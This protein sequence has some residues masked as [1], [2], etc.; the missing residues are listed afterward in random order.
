MNEPHTEAGRLAIEAEAAAL[1]GLTVERLARALT[2]TYNLD[3]QTRDPDGD[4]RRDARRIL[5]ALHE[6]ETPR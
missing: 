6:G 3:G 4:D 2:S 1:D 5:A